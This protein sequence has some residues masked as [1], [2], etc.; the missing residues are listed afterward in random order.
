MEKIVYAWRRP[1]VGYSLQLVVDHENRTLKKGYCLAIH[2]DLIMPS[3]KSLDQLADALQ[4]AGYTL[5][6]D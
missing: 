4:I 5:T 3:R 1:G 2:N 6:E